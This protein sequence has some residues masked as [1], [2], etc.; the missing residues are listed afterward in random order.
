MSEGAA[1]TD[2]AR[3]RPRSFSTALLAPHVVRDLARPPAL[4]DGHERR[5]R[6]DEDADD[7]LRKER[8]GEHNLRRV[9]LPRPAKH[10][11]PSKCLEARGEVRKA[12][13]PE[14]THVCALLAL[15]G[16]ERDGRPAHTPLSECAREVREALETA[17]AIIRVQDAVECRD[18][19]H[20]HDPW[21]AVC[22]PVKCAR[23]RR[24]TSGEEEG[25]TQIW[26]RAEG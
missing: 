25:R 4:E 21:L 22:V 7:E 23:R 20:P 9:V 3:P 1:C 14:Q 12:R 24:K 6:A 10:P 18:Q 15:S 17:Q 16:E 2:R 8:D 11:P 13:P 5:L 19:P 26:R